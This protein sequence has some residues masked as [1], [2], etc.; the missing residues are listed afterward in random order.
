MRRISFLFLFVS[1]PFFL[2]SQAS[3]Y[4]F[5]DLEVGNHIPSDLNTTR[6]A[7][8]IDVAPTKTSFLMEGNWKEFSSEVHRY[9]YKMGIDVVMYIN[10]TDFLAGNSS[11]NFYQRIL[12]TRNIKNLIFVTKTHSEVEILCSPYDGQPS[13]IANNQKV[14]RKSSPSLNRL[15]LD[16]GREVKR[17]ENAM[18][19][20]LIPNKPTFLNALAIVQNSNLKNYPGQIRRTKLA[21]EKFAKISPMASAS[22]EVKSKIESYNLQV[23]A[24]NR[25]L[26]ELLKDFPYEID[27][28]DYMSDEDLLRRRYQF[29]LRNIY[30]S[31]ESIKAMLKYKD[32]PSDAG[33]VSVIPVMPDNTTIKT[34][35]RKTLLHK[36]YIRQNIA[37]NVYVGEWDADETWQE[38]LTNYFGNMIQFFN[39]GN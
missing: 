28:V 6:T 16:F 3:I 13:L 24:K 32:A 1:A 30:A 39:K 14:F 36:F 33:Y 29:I 20:F 9:L 8:F 10:N 19:N 11:R 4:Q 26:E 21:V 37:K 38:A 17:T 35:S 34:F 18:Q 22:D 25:E 15:M 7:V 27:F 12:T 23:E 5:R 31:G 2:F